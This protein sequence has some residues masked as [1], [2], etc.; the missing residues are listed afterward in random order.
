MAAAGTVGA[1]LGGGK[2][3]A[4][5]GTV[6]R[7][8]VTAARMAAPVAAVAGAG[9][10]GYAVGTGIRNAYMTTETGQKFDDKL[11]ETIAKT[12]AV[13][14]NE[15]AKAALEA[16]AKYDQMIAEQQTNNQYS[17]ELIGSIKTLINVTSQNKPVINMPGS[18]L[19]QSMSSNSANEEKRHG[20]PPAYLMRK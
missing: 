20:A 10:A 17:K 16:Q 6:G 3:G 9:V 7:G 11:G 2:G 13:F 1:V 15:D 18:P 14:G 8:A 19:M 12:L 5:A 4:I